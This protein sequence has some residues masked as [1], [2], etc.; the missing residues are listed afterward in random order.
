MSNLMLELLNLAESLAF[1]QEILEEDKGNLKDIPDAWMKVVAK[2]YGA[3][4]GKGSEI[5]GIAN[6]VKNVSKFKTSIIDSMKADNLV[7]IFVKVDD[8]PMALIYKKSSYIGSRPE[9]SIVAIDGEKS[10]IQKGSVR[11]ER[12]YVSPNSSPTGRARTELRRKMHYYEQDAMP[13]NT[14][15]IKLQ[16]SIADLIVDDEGKKADYDN[17]FKS[18][19]IEI[20]GITVD[21]DRMAAR[22]ERSGNKPTNR[23]SRES[24]KTDLA[25]A[26]KKYLKSKATEVGKKLQDEVAETLKAVQEKIATIFDDAAEGKSGKISFDTE[27]KDLNTKIHQ[28]AKLADAVNYC[29]KRDGSIELVDRFR[30]KIGKTY[31]FDALISALKSAKAATKE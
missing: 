2:G 12:H 20:F 14:L 1:E 29:V 19:K 6:P 3:L 8:E 9:Y 28:I 15:L 23:T 13:M 30:G 18:A 17:V 5:A 21:K 31:S 27:L 11:Q 22:Q 16:G 10:K 26:D 25:A 4:G 24:M 7:A